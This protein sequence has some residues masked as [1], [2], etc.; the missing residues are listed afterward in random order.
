MI[1]F[2]LGVQ[3]GMCLI[4]VLRNVDSP[5]KLVYP[6]ILMVILLL[7]AYVE[8]IIIDTPSVHC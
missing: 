2:T 8:K 1:Q 5:D 4:Y 3:F 7:A 6:V